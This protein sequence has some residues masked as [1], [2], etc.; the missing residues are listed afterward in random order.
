MLG[1]MWARI[2]PLTGMHSLAGSSWI[3]AADAFIKPCVLSLRIRPGW[4]RR[5][6][7]GVLEATGSCD[8]VDEVVQQS[9]NHVGF[10]IL[11]KSIPGKDKSVCFMIARK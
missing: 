3:A 2:E 6:V 5:R 10:E 4:N 8:E 1:A 7:T 9:V 11:R